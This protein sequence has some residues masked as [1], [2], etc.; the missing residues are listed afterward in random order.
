[1]TITDILLFALLAPVFM[2][3][4]P[5]R[6][7][8]WGIFAGSVLAVGWLQ[9]RGTGSWDGAFELAALTVLLTVLVWWLIQPAA[10]DGGRVAQDRITLAASGGLLACIWL[11]TGVE[12]GV[13]HVTPVLSASVLVGAGA[14]SVTRTLP[15]RT[16]N[17]DT[18]R[19]GA[20]L[21]IGVIILLLVVLKTPPIARYLNALTSTET[22]TEVTPLVWLGISYVAFRLIALLRDFQYGRL[23][24]EGYS[25][26]DVMSYVLFFPAYTAG[27]IDRSQ[28]FIPELQA[29]Q[30]LDAN[31]L[32]DG[33][34]RIAVGVFKKFVVAD[35]LAL[36]AMEPTL[37]D[38]T[39]SA[40]GLWLILYIYAFQIYLDFSGYSDVAIGI[41]K[42]YGLT[43]PENFDRPYLAPNIQQFWNR[44]HITLS[45]WFRG[46]YFTPLSR[47]M[48]RLNLPRYTDVFVAQLSTMVLIG[49]WHG[50]TANFVLW[51]AWHGVGLFAFKVISD[52]TR[53]WHRNVTQQVWVKRVFLVG[54]V[55]LTFHFVALGWV[56]F[57]LPTPADSLEMLTRLFGG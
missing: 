34:M 16:D 47:A 30:P 27:P 9:Y 23:P 3:L 44:W 52:Y 54:S 36:L 33:S 51:G 6:W 46:Y 20:T 19:R 2:W 40:L 15:P 28:R 8:T 32:V 7:R 22:L 5:G 55:F 41:G 45:M 29:A 31:R 35:S 57:T 26:R 24:D 13:M 53:R 10:G 56:F 38:R 11:I 17:P 12:S 49:L 1:M 21:V 43:L 37:I 50:V 42:L 4:V 48:I 18:Y 39:D 25:L 14:I